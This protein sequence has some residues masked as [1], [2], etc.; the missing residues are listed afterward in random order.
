[1]T[2]ISGKQRITVYI[3]LVLLAAMWAFPPWVHFAR[4]A[5]RAQIVQHP[6][7]YYFLADTQQEEKY[8]QFIVFRID[9]PRLVVQSVLVSTIMAGAFI[10]SRDKRT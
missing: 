9:L 4:E 5:K 2:A 7:G 6:S 10:L 8:R 3:W 1:M